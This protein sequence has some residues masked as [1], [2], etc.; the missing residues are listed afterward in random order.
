MPWNQYL[1]NMRC[2][3]CKASKVLRSRR[4]G[5]YESAIYRISGNAPY[6]C[7]HC[8]HRFFRKS[9]ISHRQFNKSRKTRYVFVATIVLAIIVGIAIAEWSNRAP[10]TVVEP[11]DP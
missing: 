4:R 10:T 11:L 7:E 2:P 5:F 3:K 1:A 6:R 8:G 9:L